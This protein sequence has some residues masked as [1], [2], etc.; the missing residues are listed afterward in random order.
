MIELIETLIER[1]HAYPA[2]DESGD[3]YFDVRSWPAY[4][5]LTRQGIDDMEPADRR[6]PARQARPPR[7]RPVEGLQVRPSRRPRPG[8]RRGAGD[9]PAGTSSARRW[10]ASTSARPSTSTA[11]ASTCASRTTRTSR[12]SRA[13]PAM[14]FASYW[15]HNAWITTAGEKMSK[16]LGNSL[17]RARGAQA[18]AR[19]RA[20]L[21]HGLRALPLARRVQ[22]RGARRGRRRL[23]PHRDVPRP[24]GC[25]RHRLARCPRPSRPPWT[26][27][28][29]HRRPWP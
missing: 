20:A 21:L 27:T 15:L 7:L 2:A 16:S 10:R 28:S 5:E 14:P 4:G 29:P 17:P 12:P 23:P 3:V 9:D 19:H 26:T 25:D 13:R 11:A 1:G 6:R 22:L 24:A 18:R 8:P